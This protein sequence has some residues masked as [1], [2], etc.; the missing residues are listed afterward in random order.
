MSVKNF[1]SDPDR[2]QLRVLTKDKI[3]QI[4]QASLKVLSQTGVKVLLPEAVELMADAGCDVIDSDL[5][6]IPSR[7]V[8]ECL[9]SAP[10]SIT[11]FDRNGQPALQLEGQNI[12]FGTGPTI[13]YVIDVETGQRRDTTMED[14][15]KA[16]RIVDYLPNL[17]YAMTMGMSGGIDPYSQGLNPVVTDRFD[18]AAMLLNTTK[19]LMFS[20][21]NVEGLSDCYEMALAVRGGSESNFRKSP[22]IMVY[23]EPT[24]PLIHDRDPLELALFCAEKSIPLLNVSGPVAGASAPVTLAGCLVLSNTEM[25]SGLVIAQLK[26]KGAPVIYGG[27]ASPLDMRTSVNLYGGPQF[28]LDHIALKELADFYN[29]PDFNTGGCTDAKTLDQHAAID[30]TMSLVQSALV[31]SNLIHDVGYMESG[32]TACWEGIVMAD[33]I[34]D[35]L[36]NFLKGIPVDKE[37]LA[38]D[39]I[40]KQGPGGS[41]V[42]EKHTFDHFRSVWYPKLMN[43][44][45]HANWTKAGSKDLK[46]KL[47][48][49]V[50]D[51][52]ANHRP[53]PLDEQIVRTVE[54]ILERAKE[55]HPVQER[56]A[57]PLR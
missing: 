11:V 28:C 3:E 16:A 43:R 53:E 33:E 39:L 22:F 8:E 15:T 19:P 14:I 37:S 6:K 27:G 48:E 55:R 34:I 42:A 52:L 41:F 47:T 5:V 17:D 12:H 29:L 7:L 57:A 54:G 35:Y 2:P 50:Q 31:G 20:N 26:N 32:Y 23:C 56:A 24:T 51:I 40:H 10:S 45:S 21:W 1:P 46:T 44:D 36:K 9:D 13:Q 30:Y 18:F 38:L 4:H 49:K 25:L